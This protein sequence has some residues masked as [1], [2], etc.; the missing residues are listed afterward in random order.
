MVTSEQ[1]ATLTEAFESLNI[2]R[3]QPFRV[4][5]PKRKIKEICRILIKNEPKTYEWINERAEARRTY[6]VT[7]GESNN[8]SAKRINRELEKI[9]RERIK[10]INDAANRK[11]R[12]WG[13]KWSYFS[14]RAGLY[15]IPKETP[16]YATDVDGNLLIYINSNPGIR[17]VSAKLEETKNILNNNGIECSSFIK[18]YPR[19][20]KNPP[21]SSHWAN[22]IKNEY[23][24]HCRE[25]GRTF[26]RGHL[27]GIRITM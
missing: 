15:I 13:N 25:G 24:G 1:Y 19:N 7:N 8:W 10:L 17:Y 21:S 20:L 3:D 22:I 26:H 27:I 11:M 18:I 5:E 2:E 23:K 6:I 4:T 9:E 16:R 14:F 12:E